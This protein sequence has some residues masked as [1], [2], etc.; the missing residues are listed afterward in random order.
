MSNTERE[1]LGPGFFSGLAA[2]RD[3]LVDG[4]RRGICISTRV[5]P[6]EL[7][8]GVGQGTVPHLA[9][10][11]EESKEGGMVT[12]GNDRSG[13][14]RKEDYRATDDTSDAPS[15]TKTHRRCVQKL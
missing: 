10:S 5:G 11:S 15:L 13:W 12:L 7:V 6:R 9:H 8:F 2:T 1:I 3:M 14:R 4:M